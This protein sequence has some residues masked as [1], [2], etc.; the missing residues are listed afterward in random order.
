MYILTGSCHCGNIKLELKT[1]N[2]PEA[3]WLRKCPCSF[4]HKQGNI[5]LADPKGILTLKIDKKE[6]TFYY[7]MG[8]KTSER[9]FCKVC[10]VYIGGFMNHEG[11]SLCVINANILNPNEAFSPPTEINVSNQNPEERIQGRMSRWMPY[12]TS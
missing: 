12:E 4:C 9:L 11:K 6:D 1:P 10:G 2:P 7:Q 5:N 8:H 3:L